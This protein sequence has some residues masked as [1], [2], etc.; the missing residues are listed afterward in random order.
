MQE[1]RTNL[2]SRKEQEREGKRKAKADKMRR[3]KE[4]REK[5]MLEAYERINSKKKQKKLE[6]EKL[7]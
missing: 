4:I 7:Q 1:A 3:E 6:E 5:G 2:R